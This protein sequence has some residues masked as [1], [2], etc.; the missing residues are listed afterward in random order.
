M[1]LRRH[2]QRQQQQCH[3]QHLILKVVLVAFSLVENQD[4]RSNV[5]FWTFQFNPHGPS[6]LPK[7][8]HFILD[9]VEWFNPSND[10][11]LGP[12][13]VNVPIDD[14]VTNINTD[15]LPV[16]LRCV[17]PENPDQEDVFNGNG[18][19]T[20]EAFCDRNKD[21]APQEDEFIRNLTIKDRIERLFKK[22]LL[23]WI[24]VRSPN[25]LSGFYFVRPMIR[26]P[27]IFSQSSCS[28]NTD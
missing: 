10:P 5:V 21:G 6:T 17:G 28:F 26:T 16:L 18:R 9:H 19:A 2:Q 23:V 22:S 11:W 4:Q 20:L 1:W 12:D 24:L 15:P 13:G 25:Y 7:L 3:Q 8:V 27:D 14:L